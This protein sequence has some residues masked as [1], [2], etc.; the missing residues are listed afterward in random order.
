MWFLL[1]FSVSRDAL[2]LRTGVFNTDFNECNPIS[3][4]TLSSALA[5]IIGA[6]RI[7]QALAK[8]K[9]IA[10]LSFFQ[11]GYGSADEPVR[12]VIVSWIL[13]EILLLFGNLNAIGN[14]VTGHQGGP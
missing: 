6:S 14:T 13:V 7:L 10:G 4:A 12:A 8:D 9:L 3:A 11:K 2:T 5:S 1:G